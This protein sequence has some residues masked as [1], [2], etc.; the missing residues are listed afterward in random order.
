M[1]L[2][3]LLTDSSF[4]R[5]LASPVYVCGSYIGVIPAKAGIHFALMYP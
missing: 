4:Q 2:P 5:E 3:P 1:Q